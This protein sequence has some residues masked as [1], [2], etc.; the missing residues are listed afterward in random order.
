MKLKGGITARI[1]PHI[2]LWADHCRRDK[3]YRFTKYDE[4]IVEMLNKE[5]KRLGQ[6]TYLK[7]KLSTGSY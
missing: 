4:N 3:G 5:K 1:I 6:E 7:Q 2:L